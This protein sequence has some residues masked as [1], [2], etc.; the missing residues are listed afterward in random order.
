[1]DLAALSLLFVA[2]LRLYA[3][4]KSVENLAFAGLLLAAAALLMSVSGGS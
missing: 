4:P 2:W 1:M 3:P